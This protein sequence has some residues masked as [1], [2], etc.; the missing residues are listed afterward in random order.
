LYNGELKLILGLMWTLIRTYQ[1]KSSGKGV[2]TKNALLEWVRIQIPELNIKNFTIDWND[3]IALCTLMDRIEPGT[4]SHYSTLDSKNGLENCKL[5]IRLAYERLE[6]PSI[7]SPDDFH[8]CDVDELS[9]MT[10]ISYFYRRWTSKLLEWI[11]SMIPYRNVQ[12]LGLDWCSGINLVALCNAINPGMLTDWNKLDPHAAVDNIAM[13]MKGAQE[14]LSIQPLFKPAQMANPE[15][16]EMANSIYLARFMYAKAIPVPTMVQARGQGLKRAFVGKNADFEVDATKGGDGSLDVKVTCNNA[17]LDVN[18][19]T[20]QKGMY[21]L[22]YV[23]EKSGKINIEIKWSGV[24]IPGSPYLVDVIDPSGLSVSSKYVTGSQAAIVGK[25]VPIEITGVKATNDLNVSITHPDGSKET[26][27]MAVKGKGVEASYIPTRVGEDDVQ[28]KYSDSEVPGSPFKVLVVDPKQC[29]VVYEDPPPGQS[30]IIGKKTTFLITAP[31]ENIQGIRVESKSPTTGLR[32]LTY[33]CRENNIYAGTYTPTEVGDHSVLVSCGGDPVR[34]SPMALPV[35]DPFKCAF[36]EGIPKNIIIHKSKEV[37]VTT[38]GAGVSKLE[39]FSTVPSV[40]CVFLSKSGPDQY[41][42]NLEAKAIGEANIELRWAGE[43]VAQTPFTIHVCD[44]SKVTVSGPALSTG[45]AKVFETI[46]LAVHAENAGKADLDLKPTNPSG[47]VYITDITD[48]GNGTYLVTFKPYEIGAHEIWATWGGVSIPKSPFFTEICKAIDIGTFTATGDGLSKIIATHINTFEVISTETGL[49]KDGILT[50]QFEGQGFKSVEVQ[51]GGLDSNS[52][53]IQ[54]TALDS[55]K[56]RYAIE[57]IVPREGKYK[58]AVLCEGENIKDSPFEITALPPADASQCFAFGKSLEPG[59]WLNVGKPIEFKVDCTKAGTGELGVTAQDPNNYDLNAYTADESARGEIIHSIKLDVKTVGVH[60]V[61]VR[62]SSIGIPKSPFQFDIVDPKLVNIINMPK[63]E[64]FIAKVGE[65]IVFEI[66]ASKAGNGVLECKALANRDTKDEFILTENGKGRY[67]AKYIPKYVGSLEFILYYNGEN[68]LPLPWYCEVVDPTSFT[69]NPPTQY[70]RQKEY[71]KFTITGI[72]PDTK[73]V[74][75]KC[76]HAKHDATVKIEFANEIATARFTPKQIGDYHCEVTCGGQHVSGSPFI[77]KICNPDNCKFSAPPP[78]S[79]HLNEPENVLIKT[80]GC[81]PGEMSCEIVAVTGG[82]PMCHKLESSV[83]LETLTLEP[84][85]IGTFR[86]NIFWAGYVIPG[87]PFETNAIDANA[88]RVECPSLQQ[89]K[90]VTGQEMQFFI[91][92]RAAGPITANYLHFRGIGPKSSYN[93]TTTDNQNGTYTVV[94]VPWQVGR[95]YAEINWGGK[96]VQGSP[97]IFELHKAVDV[98]KMMLQGEGLKGGVEG[99][100]GIVNLVGADRG[101]LEKGGLTATFESTSGEVATVNLLEKGNG[102][103]QI[104]YVA[105]VANQYNL[106]VYY[107]NVAVA[108]TPVSIPILPAPN[109]SKCIPEGALISD[110]DYYVDDPVEFSVNC[111]DAGVGK[112]AVRASAPTGATIRVFT[113][114]EESCDKIMYFLKFD[115]NMVGVYKVHITWEGEPIPGSPYSINVVDPSKCV[116]KGLPLK[117]NGMAVLNEQILFTVSTKGAGRGKLTSTV[118]YDDDDEEIVLHKQDLKQDLSEFKFTPSKSGAFSILVKYSK[119]SV[120]GS[121]FKCETLDTSAFGIILSK[122]KE[123]ALV[124][125]PFKFAIKGQLPPGQ[126]VTAVA[127]GP[128][129]DVNVDVGPPR[130]DQRNAS[131]IP[132]QPGSYEVFVECA[133]QQ[134]PGSPFTLQAVDPGKCQILG[135]IPTVLQVGQQEDF[136]VKTVGAGI[137]NITV[138]ANDEKVCDLVGINVTK[139][140]MDTFNVRLD[141]RAIGEVNIQVLFAGYDIPKTPF[142]A[143]ICDASK[144]RA[145]GEAIDEQSGR[146]AEPVIFTVVARGAGNAKLT[147]KPK[148]PTAQYAVDIQEVKE[149]TYQVSFTPWEVGQH[150]VEVIWG[151]AH[152]PKSPFCIRVGNRIMANMCNATGDGLKNAIAEQPAYFTVISSEVGLVDKGYLEILVRGI[153]DA[154]KVTVKDNNDG[155]Y[156]VSYVAP[157]E[158]AYVASITFRGNPIPGSPFKINVVPGPDASKCRAYGPALHPN[159]VHISGSPLEFFVDTMEAG[160]GELTVT[161]KGPDEYQPKVFTSDDGEGVYSV[162]FDAKRHGRY[163]V[164]VQWSKVQIPSSPLKLKVHPRANAG[165]V[166]VYGPGLHNGRLGDSGE[167]TIETKD[168]GIGTLSIRV[169]GIKDAFRIEAKQHSADDP[170]TLKAKYHPSIPGQYVIFIRW[171]GDHVPGSPFTVDIY[172]DGYDGTPKSPLNMGGYQYPQSGGYT[173]GYSQQGGYS[174]SEVKTKATTS[175]TTEAKDYSKMTKKERKAA[176]KEEKKR[177]KEAAKKAKK[178]KRKSTSYEE[179][180]IEQSDTGPNMAMQPVSMTLHTKRHTPII[181]LIT[182]KLFSKQWCI[183]MLV[184]LYFNTS[185]M[186]YLRKCI[187]PHTKN[188]YKKVTQRNNF[189]SIKKPTTFLSLTHFYHLT[190]RMNSFYMYLY[191]K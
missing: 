1:L 113:D 21:K 58:I 56:G 138:L 66:D 155:S 100:P 11:Q 4:C 177:A 83:N 86:I 130:E 3:G 27:K 50:F 45:K 176:E 54:Y 12:N 76:V 20:P 23:P 49:L 141:P 120:K 104:T 183:Y 110:E 164:F 117:N 55:G 7:I 137:G 79:L 186:P 127:H 15:P 44:P 16:D 101:L 57:Y 85:E 5:G 162:K 131:F 74:K 8:S 126:Q 184:T 25:P 121:P 78:K 93:A 178:V 158:G 118:Q 90:L 166:R 133:Q 73:N 69:V 62:W 84:S 125:E 149:Q 156:S 60:K 190:Y 188:V 97:F 42:L 36:T 80:D 33:S 35:A 40:V 108:G 148:G 87:C 46:E 173:S 29:S 105:S 28:V 109:A 82:N 103:Y 132:L 181:E 34:G 17:M 152:I 185:F 129:A 134:V 170:R 19:Q 157:T 171:S 168:A 187:L 32:E 81:G 75:A 189:T 13:A 143:Q 123:G 89:T 22:I 163:F 182:K 136:D 10:Y 153:K 39:A 115:P 102:V 96:S 88:I 9:V 114:K 99:R 43:T 72:T 165:M 107:D 71:V 167:F 37:K 91:D 94:L 52:R 140:D 24:H 18:T 191:S 124:C 150:Y 147:V 139:E 119:R 154:A 64:G 70:G 111:T 145:I 2:S 47:D 92:A 116:V 51:P 128:Q 112:L 26:A 53:E 30:A 151:I 77:V 41:D 175:E 63:C 144:C 180:V 98:S 169:H 6:I 67:E 159:A 14:T 174:Q 38:K 48:N 59:V 106:M 142:R 68:L 146:V 65:P 95:N 161:A 122:Q 61:T 31:G 172:G 135:T 179:E 160:C